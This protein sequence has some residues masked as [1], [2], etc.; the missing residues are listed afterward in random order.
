MVVAQAYNPRNGEIIGRHRQNPGSKPNI[1]TEADGTITISVLSKGMEDS[2]A[3][4][5]SV[6]ICQ[7]LN[8]KYSCLSL[9]H[10]TIDQHRETLSRE[11]EKRQLT[12]CK[13][14]A[15]KSWYVSSSP[16]LNLQSSFVFFFQNPVIHAIC[17]HSQKT[18]LL[19]SRKVASP[20]IPTHPNPHHNPQAKKVIS[21]REQKVKGAHSQAGLT[22]LLSILFGPFWSY[23]RKSLLLA[24]KKFFFLC[25]M[26]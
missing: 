22:F 15:T 26:I 9:N 3:H 6:L 8:D 23:T 14:W 10:K 13:R 25:L 24:S 17:P 20:R 5:I 16:C 12:T 4:S 11:G 2:L 1:S 7:L 19:P 21:A 18:K